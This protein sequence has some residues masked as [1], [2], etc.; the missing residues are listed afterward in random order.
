MLTCLSSVTT[1]GC[2]YCL[3]LKVNRRMSRAKWCN[4][5]E[6]LPYTEDR[7]L[8]LHL[9]QHCNLQHWVM[10][11]AAINPGTNR[12]FLKNWPG[13]QKEEVSG[14]VCTHGNP[15]YWNHSP[16]Q[17]EI[18]W[19]MKGN[20][21]ALLTNFTKCFSLYVVY[22]SILQ[23]LTTGLGRAED[24]CLKPTGPDRFGLHFYNFTWASGW[25]KFGRA[26]ALSGLTF[27]ARFQL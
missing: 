24:L 27:K 21:P 5:T 9:V 12:R 22:P 20:N 26:R 8:F 14:R 6:W 16:S 25:A 2:A 18:Y 10:W 13:A 4:D 1:Q 7:C 23:P 17:A 19:C 15:S 11:V 3:T